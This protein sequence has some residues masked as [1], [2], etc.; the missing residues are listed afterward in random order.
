M[1]SNALAR[2]RE[3]EKALDAERRLTNEALARL[4]TVEKKQVEQRPM[5]RLIF[6]LDLTNS[7][8]ATLKQA[9]IAT[10]SMFDAIAAIG[11][12]AVKLLYFRGAS[13]CRENVWYEDYDALCRSM[14]KLSCKAGATQLYRLLS[15]ALDEKE[16]IAGVVYV[17]D[18]CEEDAHYLADLAE[19]LGKKGVPLYIFHECGGTDEQFTWAQSIFRRMAEVS[20][21]VYAEFKPDSG[22]ALKEML[23]SIAAY[24]T[25]GLSGLERLS[26]PATAPARQLRAGMRL[27]IGA[28]TDQRK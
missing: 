17:G 6:G 23:A 8:D 1:M 10:A 12:I 13:E 25:Q 20:G 27:M 22:E 9:R 26:I 11:R 2:L 16:K 5:S 14:L 24:A 15:K 21:G 18:H 4:A 28:G 19:K 3:S 7:R